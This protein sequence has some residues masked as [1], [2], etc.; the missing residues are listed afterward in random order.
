MTRTELPSGT[1]FDAAGA[2]IS[3]LAAMLHFH[4]T[5]ERWK[6]RLVVANDHAAHSRRWRPRPVLRVVPVC[7]PQMRA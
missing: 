7:E 3:T 4:R 2:S 6:P 1:A 5:G